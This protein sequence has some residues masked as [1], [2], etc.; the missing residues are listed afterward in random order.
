MNRRNGS[1][2]QFSQLT[3]GL[4]RYGYQ[5]VR[6]SGLGLAEMP[7]V[8]IPGGVVRH[9][10]VRAFGGGGGGGIVPDEFPTVYGD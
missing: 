6:G 8:I 10:G 9:P 2:R 3:R 4:T 5:P 1:S 7:L